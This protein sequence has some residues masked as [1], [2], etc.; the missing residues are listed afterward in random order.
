MDKRVYRERMRRKKR[1]LL[2]RRCVR[3]AT[4]VVGL[5]LV[6]VF[7]VRGIIL[8]IVRHVGGE[9]P[10]EQ[11]E[12]QAETAEADPDA[13]IRRPVKGQGDAAKVTA[14]TPGW[15]DSEDG[16]WYR[17]TDG[18]YYAGGFK[19]IDGIT[20]SFDE[21]G[22]IQTGW[23][24]RGFDDYYFNEDGSYNPQKK[25]P[26]LALTYDDGPGEFTDQ[27]L[28]CLEEN[29]AHATFF[30]LGSNV[31]NYPE[32]VQ[33]MVELGCE[34]GSH[35]YDHPDLT[36]LSLEAA[37]EQYTRTDELLIQACGQSATVARAPGGSWNSD[38]VNA[39][40]KPFFTW[41]LDTLDWQT[42]N[43]DS[44]YNA[45]INGDLTDGS[46]ILMHDIHQTSVEASL[47]IIPELVSMGYKLVTVSEL[48]AAKGVDL[49]YA[50]YSDFWQSTLDRGDVPGYEGNASSEESSEEDSGEGEL[51][52]GTDQG[53]SGYSDG[54]VSDGSDGGSEDDFNDGSYDDGEVSD[55][56]NE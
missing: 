46:I 52:D 24:S 8:P 43:V 34:I 15:H 45:V 39:V 30:M 1:Q 16:K 32:A 20:Y 18:T 35:S 6:I 37:K 31:P 48:A 22:Y 49:Q 11:V 55:G 29:N 21:N 13:A 53:D 54:A 12:V 2:I 28:D 4:Y 27:L 51:T 26:M 17:N 40:E 7:V 19:E 9:D 23:V 47:K 10:G 50:S 36:S 41:S 14:M 44:N 3:L 38:V 33:R 5:I 56:T 25:R 42:R